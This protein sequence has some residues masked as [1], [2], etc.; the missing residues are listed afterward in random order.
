MLLG[1]VIKTVTAKAVGDM[2]GDIEL[3]PAE[4]AMVTQYKDLIREQDK[5]L[6]DLKLTVDSLKHE[7]SMLAAQNQELDSLLGQLRDQNMVLRAQVL[8]C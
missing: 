7:N 4:S 1:M 2:N 5:R 8:P 3:S 6:H